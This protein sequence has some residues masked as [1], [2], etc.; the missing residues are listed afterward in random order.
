MS[1]TLNVRHPIAALLFIAVGLGLQAK[2]SSIDEMVEPVRVI[3]WE[4]EHRKP[5]QKVFSTKE[6]LDSACN[7][8]GGD[9]E[10]L[11]KLTLKKKSW[12]DFLPE[13]K[14]G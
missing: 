2:A 4:G 1:A 3:K 14:M 7:A 10:K 6:A 9:S 13:R 8:D 5:E 12:L 11:P